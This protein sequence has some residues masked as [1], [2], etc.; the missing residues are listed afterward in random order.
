[1]TLPIFPQAVQTTHVVVQYTTDRL[2][3]GAITDTQAGEIASLAEQAYAAAAAVGYTI[4]GDGGLG[5]DPRVDIRI[6]PLAGAGV[7]ADTRPDVN[8]SP[9]TAYV[10]LNAAAGSDAFSLDVLAHEFFHIVQMNIWLPPTVSDYW[11]LEGSAEWLGFKA[12]GYPSWSLDDIAG[13]WSMSLDCRNSLTQAPCDLIDDYKGNGYTRWP[14]FE[15]LWERYGADAIT[16]IFSQAA[17]GGGPATAALA[18]ELAAKGTSL[19]DFFTDWAV[20]NATGDYTAKVLQSIPPGVYGSPIQTGTL[21]LLNLTTKAGAPKV[22]SGPIPALT[23]PVNHLAVRY[24]ELDRGDTSAPDTPCYAA[25]L[26][27]NVTVPSDTGA[28]PYFWWSQRG[29]DGKNLQRAQALTMGSDGNGT[30]TVPWDTCDWGSTKGYL[31]L[32]NPS[33]TVD[34][35]SFTVSGTL[36]VDRSTFATAAPPPDPVKTHGADVDA[37]S[38][39]G[40]SGDVPQIAVFG[41]QVLRL[42]PGQKQLRLIVQ[43]DGSGKLK[44]ALGSLQL[45]TKALRAGGNDLRFA[46]PTKAL[47]SVRKVSA[48]ASV[49]TL[50]PLSTGGAAGKPVTRQVVVQAPRR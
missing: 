30:I 26:R 10:E 13:D 24:V 31:I 6:L 35:A 19:G 25:S 38:A 4:P 48:A 39:V 45:G 5:G 33:T 8:G 22:T 21:A 40:G 43:S 47:K 42:T 20:A 34:G 32:S 15:Y 1:L 3:P 28:R 9:T 41:P 27:V 29:K 12:D 50:T 49:L 11:L 37:S 23:V 18:R 2:V 46:L 7:L 44:A 17:S 36:T 16:G 14:F